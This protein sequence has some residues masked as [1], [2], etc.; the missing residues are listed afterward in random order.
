[1]RRT[2]TLGLLGGLV[3]FVWGA[4][5][6]MALPFHN[7]TMH[8]LPNGAPI[9]EA[10]K[11]AVT[12]PGVYMYPSD[13]EPGDR[14]D[15]AAAERW[16]A[17]YR[18]GPVITQMVVLPKGADP[19]PV[20]GFVRY[21]VYSAVAAALVA[22]MLQLAIGSL[23]TTLGRIGFVTAVGAV[24]AFVGPLTEGSWWHHPAGYALVNAADC[25]VG[26]ALVGAVF[27][28]RLRAA[29]GAVPSYSPMMG[30]AERKTTV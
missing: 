8:G 18:A 7:M 15:K 1:M 26:W 22:W 27:A 13:M 30:G 4:V 10:V 5:S 16:M 2:I 23:P 6:W 20:M 25:V 17:Q 9:A 11:A 24:T 28:W 14:D 21:F 3:I 12:E 29:P 19:M